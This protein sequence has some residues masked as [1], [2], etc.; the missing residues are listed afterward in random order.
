MS[1]PVRMTRMKMAMTALAVVFLAQAAPVLAAPGDEDQPQRE[2][3]PSRAEMNHDR[4]QRDGGGGRDWRASER[5]REAPRPAEAPR[6]S[7][8]P[9]APE[10]TRAPEA[11]R[12]AEPRA[13]DRVRVPG[14]SVGRPGPWVQDGR[15]ASVNERGRDNRP[16]GDR[17]GGDHNDHGSRDGDRQDGDRRDGDRYNG[18]RRDGGRYDNDRRDG[19]HRDG[20]HWDGAHRDGAHRDGDRHDDRRRWEHGRYPSV[21]FSTHRY[22]N[23][24]RPP[25][26]FYVRTWGFGD[27][28][29]RG[30]Y[31]QQYYLSDPWNYDLPLAPPGYI[32]VRVGY[33]ALLVDDYGGRVVQVVRNVFW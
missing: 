11:T 31:G 16:D 6:P 19:A 32:W 14:D 28:L 26:G 33:D 10:P 21:Y 1:G 23:Y 5:V 18:D 24:W 8:G 3:Q 27:F 30:W 12:A 13:Q 22:R 4:P 15:G 7:E 17:R 9:R 25:S 29:P 2:D 20:G